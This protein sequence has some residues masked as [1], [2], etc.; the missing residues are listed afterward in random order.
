M[1]DVFASVAR[2]VASFQRRK[3]QGSFRSW[4]ATITRNK[5]RYLYRQRGGRPAAKGGTDAHK[6]L[7]SIADSPPDDSAGSG[8]FSAARLSQRALEVIKSEFEGRTWQIFCLATIDGRPATEIA[9]DFGLTKSA[10][11]QAKYRVL[12]RLR[13]ELEGLVDH[14]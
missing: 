4:L 1:Q 12:K 11:R 9:Q 5:V 10:V 14:L 6:R 3:E 7:E 2:G 13:D 8:T